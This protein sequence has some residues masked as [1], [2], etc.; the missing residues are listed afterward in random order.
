MRKLIRADYSRT[1]L[2]PPSIED[3]VSADHPARF[4]RD[5]VDVLDLEELGFRM[6][7]ALD[8]RPPYASDLLLGVWLYGYM[9]KIRS[10]RKLEA[11]CRE[12]MSCIWLTGANYPDHNTLWRFWA[13]NRK[14]L[15]EVFRQ[16]VS[17]ACKAD[18]VSCV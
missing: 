1:Y 8:G 6:P 17:V 7:E 18:L 12:H 16:A 13:A 5:F 2:L 11:A 3:W 4:I 14:A 10:S 9:N 15:R